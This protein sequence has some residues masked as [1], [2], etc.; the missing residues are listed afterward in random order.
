MKLKPISLAFLCLLV[1]LL[2][3]SQNKIEL[4]DTAHYLIDTSVLIPTKD[5]AILSAVVVRKKGITRKTAN[6][7][8]LLYLF[9]YGAQFT[10]SKIFS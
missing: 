1:N 4:P 3:L 9:Q 6:G 8:V 5:G 7:F 2:A 10:G